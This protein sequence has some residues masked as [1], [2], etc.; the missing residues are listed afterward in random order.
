MS[1]ELCVYVLRSLLALKAQMI[2]M[3][4]HLDAIEVGATFCFVIYRESKWTK[5][6][7]TKNRKY[8]HFVNC[9][10][11]TTVSCLYV[12]AMYIRPV[13][14]SRIFSWQTRQDQINSKTIYFIFLLILIICCIG[15]A[16]VAGI[17]NDDKNDNHKRPEK[18]QSEESEGYKKIQFLS[19]KSNYIME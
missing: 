12:Y 4:C 13:R 19:T 3:I 10:C 8:W 11:N 18:N 15:G 16:S 2:Q 5:M 6:E 17:I 9:E 7:S 14:S 1:Q